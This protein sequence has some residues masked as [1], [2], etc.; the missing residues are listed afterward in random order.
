MK[1]CIFFASFLYTNAI[2]LAQEA[3]YNEAAYITEAG[4]WQR[5]VDAAPDWLIGLVPLVV[6]FMIGARALA[7]I[8]FIFKD[9]TETKWDNKI[10]QYTVKVVDVL[11]KILGNIGVGIPS[12]MAAEKVAKLEEKKQ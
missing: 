8:L 9:K 1:T 5:F 6:A 7:E 10:W 3:G 11:A 4:L 12:K 2:L